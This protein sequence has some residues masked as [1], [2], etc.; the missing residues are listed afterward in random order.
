MIRLGEMNILRVVRKSDLGYMLTDGSTEI[1]MHFKQATQELENG[2]EVSVFVYSDKEKRFTATMQ[3]PKATLDMPGFV[4]VVE[5]LPKIGVF[6][7][8]NTPKDV[9]ISKDYL[10]YSEEEWP[11]VGDVL[12]IRLKLKGNVLVGKPL[13]RFEIN[14]IKSDVCYADYEQIEGYIC[15]ITEKGIGIITIH[16]VYVFVPVSQYRGT[17]R[18]G[19]KV[20]VSI[21]KS[22]AGECYGTLNAH[23]EELIDGDRQTILKYLDDHHG[24]MK[25]TSKSGAEEIERTF[26]M[27]RKA[28]KRAYGGLYRDRLIE[29]DEEKT[30]KRKDG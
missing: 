9:L 21:T 1:L 14:E 22:M 8:I 12:F 20:N 23:K 2:N 18:M 11:V 17:I 4:E 3:K 25:F 7:H 15:R 28:F 16:R 13:N 30:Y 26:H 5:V 19:Q 27:S 10:P 29:F 24:V 6:V